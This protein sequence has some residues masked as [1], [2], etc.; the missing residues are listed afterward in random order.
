MRLRVKLVYDL[1]CLQALIQ[2]CIFP[3]RLS[4]NLLE[5]CI[6]DVDGAPID[7]DVSASVVNELH[8]EV[9]PFHSSNKYLRPH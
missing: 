3:I 2:H 5:L 9:R 7:P 6:A 8:L 1:I 4:S